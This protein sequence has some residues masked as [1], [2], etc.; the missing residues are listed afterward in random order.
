MIITKLRLEEEHPMTSP[1]R[2]WPLPLLDLNLDFSA[3]D[4]GY[5]LKG[6][7]GLGP[8]TL[9]P[10]VIGFDATGTPIMDNIAQKRLISLKIGLTPKLN[11]TYGDLRDALY[12]FVSRGMF[13]KLMYGAEIICQTRGFIKNITP[14]AFT[15][16][17]EIIIDIECNEGDFAAPQP[18]NVP[19]ATLNTLTPVIVYE[20]G[21]A[22][23]GID[24]TYAVTA[25]HSGF[26]ISNHAEFWHVGE[27]DVT[28]QFIVSY[29]FLNGDTIYISTHP[30]NKRITRVRAGVEMDLAGYINPGAVWPK[31]YSGVNSFAWTFASSW[32]HFTAASY[33]PRYWG[34]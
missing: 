26:T 19:I 9:V 18:N 13:V 10:V 21:S 32:G 7:S 2:S 20:Q 5:T 12:K 11:Q 23:A 4:N 6:S 14:D 28:N 3:G 27:G 30:K 31:L 16:K 34:V 8:P 1:S 15:N 33:I 24:L 29:T 17:P 25:T 22:P